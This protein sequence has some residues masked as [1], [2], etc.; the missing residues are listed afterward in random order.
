MIGL[1]ETKSTSAYKAAS[2][3]HFN[4]LLQPVGLIVDK[5][6]LQKK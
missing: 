3:V 1:R 4:F 5:I 2:H 6:N